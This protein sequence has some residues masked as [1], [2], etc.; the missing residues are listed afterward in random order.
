MNCKSPSR[1]RGMSVLIVLGLLAITLAVSYAMMRTQSTNIQIHNN[2]QRRGDARQ[3]A[4]AGLSMA[5]RAMQQNNWAG[6]TSTL[7]RNV[8]E[9]TSC[10]VTY[11]TGDA[12]LLPGSA[13]Y[14][15]WPYRVT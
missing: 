7:S 4:Y 2:Y 3:A 5:L 12:A 15:E 9:G 8:G 11:E 6:V 14:A 10:Y 1:R 13:S